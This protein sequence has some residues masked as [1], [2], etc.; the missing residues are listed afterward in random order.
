[1][2]GMPSRAAGLRGLFWAGGFRGQPA[3]ILA[4]ALQDVFDAPG[5]EGSYFD[6]GSAAYS[7]ACVATGRLDA[8]VD[9]GAAILE[10][11]PDIRPVWERIGGGKALNT[12]TYDVAAAGLYATECGAIVTDARGPFEE[13]PLLDEDGKASEVAT[14]AAGNPDV[15]ERLVE[16][17]ARGTQR[18]RSVVEEL[19]VEPFEV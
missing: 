18:V 3:A 14:I 2:D 11:V 12:V 19:G 1:R 10:A 17:F 8:F 15:H 13:I 5:S 6:Q 7:L 16:A 9:P 4:L